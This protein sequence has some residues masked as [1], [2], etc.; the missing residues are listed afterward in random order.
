VEFAKQLED[1][2]HSRWDAAVR[3]RA[4]LMTSFAFIFGVIP[5]VWAISAGANA[6]GARHCG[7]FRHD[8]SDCSG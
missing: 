7:I 2:G 4:D 5:L 1:Q 3:P 8:R 6:P